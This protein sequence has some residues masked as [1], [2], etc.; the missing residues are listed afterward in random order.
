VDYSSKEPQ[1]IVNREEAVVNPKKDMLF[2]KKI[3]CRISHTTFSSARTFAV[4]LK[5]NGIAS[6]IGQPSGGKP[7]SYGLPRRDKT[8]HYQIPFRVSRCEFLR[9]DKERDEE[10][11]LMPELEE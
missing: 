8:P 1:V 3:L 2:P 4:T 6:V 11:A 5:D 10:T 9:P 7:T